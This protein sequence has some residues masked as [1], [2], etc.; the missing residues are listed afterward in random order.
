MSRSYSLAFAAFRSHARR[1]ANGIPLPA[2]SCGC[3]SGCHCRSRLC[4]NPA[5]AFF[6]NRPRDVSVRGRRSARDSEHLVD[7][8]LTKRRQ[9][10]NAIVGHKAGIMP[11]EI[12]VKPAARIA[13]HRC[14]AP[15]APTRLVHVIARTLK[16]KPSQRFV[17]PAH[18]EIVE[19]LWRL[20]FPD[21]VLHPKFVIIFSM[22]SVMSHAE[23]PRGR[24]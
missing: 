14:L 7:D 2:T 6:R 5:P 1:G 15:F 19:S 13:E 18:H 20:V 11:R 9:S 16:P 8:R 17:V 10:F 12:L 4:R 3:H 24:A 22:L 21:V 23:P